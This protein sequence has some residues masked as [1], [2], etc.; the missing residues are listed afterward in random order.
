MLPVDPTVVV[1][2]YGATE[3][4]IFC[5]LSSL[6]RQMDIEA[7]VDLFYWFKEHNTVKLIVCPQDKILR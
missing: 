6:V 5:V 3:A 1:D 7:T 4:G 2:S